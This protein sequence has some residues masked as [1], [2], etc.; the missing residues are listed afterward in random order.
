MRPRLRDIRA[1]WLTG[2]LL[3][4]AAAMITKSTPRPRE[5]ARRGI[6]RVLRAQIDRFDSERTCQRQPLRIDVDAEHRTA[7]R[8]QQLRRQQSDQAQSADH[9]ALAESR[10]GE[11]NP[12]Q[13]DRS[14]DGERR[15]IVVDVVGNPRAQVCRDGHDLGVLPVRSDP[16][17]ERE[18]ADPG[19]DVEHGTDVAVAQRQRLVELCAHRLVGRGETVGAHLLD[20]LFHPFRLLAGLVDQVCAP[21]LEQHPLGAGRDQRAAGPNQELPR[22]AARRGNVFEQRA[23]GPQI[24]ENLLQRDTCS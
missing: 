17:A 16:V 5:N 10:R 12:L 13:R 2:S 7:V 4:V 22:T 18:A 21:E 20:D 14:H 24:L 6:D 19:A 1:A 3:L 8:A 15:R 23:A 9:D 11:P